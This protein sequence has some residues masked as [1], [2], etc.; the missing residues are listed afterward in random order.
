MRCEENF[1]SHQYLSLA[2]L[3]RSGSRM[4]LFLEDHR[5]LVFG[6]ERRKSMVHSIRLRE[7]GWHSG[8]LLLTLKRMLALQTKTVATT[9]SSWG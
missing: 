7:P 6:E 9:S 3:A 4:E 1:V 2:Y 5:S 8:T